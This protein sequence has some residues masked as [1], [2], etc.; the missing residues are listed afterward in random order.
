MSILVN[1]FL[2]ETRP[3]TDE[4]IRQCEM[5]DVEL[6]TQLDKLPSQDVVVRRNGSFMED[7]ELPRA[8][9]G[10]T[11]KSGSDFLALTYGFLTRQM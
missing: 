8:N 5:P 6:M 4:K 7:L 3:R 2:F 10:G 1:R 11:A 9:S